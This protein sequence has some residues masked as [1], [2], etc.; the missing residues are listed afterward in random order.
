MPKKD[1]DL[2]VI[3]WKASL[4]KALE[5]RSITY[6]SD[7]ERNLHTMQGIW[8]DDAE[9]ADLRDLLVPWE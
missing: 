8:P 2:S 5:L 4:S 6:F 3:L 7:A 1:K 9:I